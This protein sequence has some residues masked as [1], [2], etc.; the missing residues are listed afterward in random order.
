MTE[1]NVALTFETR[2]A[3]LEARRGAWE[4]GEK[5]CAEVGSSVVTSARANVEGRKR[6]SQCFNGVCACKQREQWGAAG[7]LDR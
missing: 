7:N 1:T 6:I 2:A 4:R 3:K 5:D